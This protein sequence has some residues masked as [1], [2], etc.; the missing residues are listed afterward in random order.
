MKSQTPAADTTLAAL[1]FDAVGTLSEGFAILGTDHKVIYANEP[2]WAHHGN[3][4]RMYDRGLTV[5]DVIYEGVKRTHPSL[6]EAVARSTA[7]KLTTRLLSGKPTDL[8]TDNGRIA[9]T[10]YRTMA[11][12][13][14]VAVS[15]DITELRQREL[16]L[17][18]ARISAE[19]ANTAKSQFLA[20]M[21]HELR[22]P[23]NA[24]LGFSE[25]ISSEIM[26]AVPPRYVDYAR[27]IHNSGRH[28]LALINDVLDVSKLE[29]GKFEL[30]ESEFDLKT[31][32]SACL[33][34]VAVQARAEGIHIVENCGRSPTLRADERLVRQ[35]LLNVLSNAVKF[36]P[37]EGSITVSVAP[38]ANGDLQIAIA[39]TGIGMTR[40]ETAVALSAF[41]QVDSK[42]SRQHKGTGL[43]LPIAKSMMQLHGGELL[44]QSSPSHGTTVI[45]VFPKSRVRLD[46][47]KS[48][49][50]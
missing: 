3:A 30:C 24:I 19:A 23:L 14:I 39:D 13:F 45:L 33:A 10:T 46:R 1:V 43:G 50:K 6:A 32:V 49:A 4:Y 35:V 21:S 29:A 11:N 17:K 2:S 40:D 34:L 31:V 28:L 5:V 8:I 25:I 41:G 9:R 20:T 36:T 47:R 37:S 7:Q 27:D 16:E 38:Q 12:G 44:V 18:E 15:T 48:S 42:I 22:T 26:G